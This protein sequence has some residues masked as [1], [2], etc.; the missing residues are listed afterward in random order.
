M[1]DTHHLPLS[2]DDNEKH[3]EA[4]HA[5][6]ADIDL[7]VDVTHNP[8]HKPRAHGSHR[9][10]A[11]NEDEDGEDDFDAQHAQQK[12]RPLGAQDIHNPYHRLYAHQRH[13]GKHL[14]TH[15]LHPERANNADVHDTHSS[16][17]VH[18]HDM[19]SS[20]ELHGHGKHGDV[21]GDKDLDASHTR[22]RDASI[23]FH[24]I[25]HPYHGFP[26]QSE[27]GRK[28]DTGM[29]TGSKVDSYVHSVHS[30]IHTSKEARPS[31]DST[32]HS[33][34][35]G[36]GTNKSDAHTIHAVYAKHPLPT[37]FPQNHSSVPAYHLGT[38]HAGHHTQHRGRSKT[39]GNFSTHGVGR[40]SN[41]LLKE[42]IPDIVRTWN[43]LKDATNRRFPSSSSDIL[44]AFQT[45]AA[46][47]FV[48]LSF[49]SLPCTKRSSSGVACEQYSETIQEKELLN[50]SRKGLNKYVVR[51]VSGGLS[52]E[53]GSWA[54]HT[55]NLEQI[56]HN[57]SNSKS[58]PYI[59]QNSIMSLPLLQRISQSIHVL[60]VAVARAHVPRDPQYGDLLKIFFKSARDTAKTLKACFIRSGMLPQPSNMLLFAH[61]VS[62]LQC[63]HGHDYSAIEA[64]HKA[65]EVLRGEPNATPLYIFISDAIQGVA[66]HAVDILNTCKQNP[67][68]SR[69]I[70]CPEKH[71]H[72]HPSTNI[73]T[74]STK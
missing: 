64:L 17:E 18:G 2:S 10:Y 19:H 59:S 68:C 48:A 29:S 58:A 69:H 43:K 1:H 65:A 57:H 14:D 9:Y 31:K 38:P 39:Q 20:R 27:T 56:L 37:P 33:L 44:Q 73:H 67:N 72:P 8:M 12:Y 16:R 34:P 4:R 13:D 41:E 45:C 62:V 28:A 21:D 35:P 46:A 25:H 49:T 42:H 36:L 11:D 51:I 26:L 60:D 70:H 53:T 47:T 55:K 63:T 40:K 50:R 23:D 24:D 71:P 7:G 5:Q 30:H 54:K 32:I 15:L 22:K 3:R 61:E 52:G 6:Q 74:S 66:R